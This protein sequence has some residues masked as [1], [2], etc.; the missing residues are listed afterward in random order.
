[1]KIVACKI[2]KEEA[3]RFKQYA[4][5]HNTTPNAL[6]R[7]YVRKCINE[8]KR[9]RLWPLEAHGKTLIIQAGFWASKFGRILG[10]IWALFGK[11]IG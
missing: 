1:M 2:K 7:E 4:Q 10:A 8:W 11:N 6:L 5:D 3:E 9:L